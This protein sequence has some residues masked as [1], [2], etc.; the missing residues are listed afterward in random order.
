[1]RLTELDPHWFVL[2]QGGPRVGVSFDCPH[3][4]QVRIAVAFHHAGRAAMEDGYI[5]AK[6]GAQDSDHIWTLA[7]PEDFEVMTLTPSVDASQTGHWHGFIT[8]GGVA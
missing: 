4:R 1:M 8:N 2:E 6:H 5:L 3:C 7:G